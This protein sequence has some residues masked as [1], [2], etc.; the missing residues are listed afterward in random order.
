[1]P[2]IKL[3]QKIESILLMANVKMGGGGGQGEGSRKES[4]IC[5]SVDL[6]H[7]QVGE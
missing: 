7:S 4:D 1:M 2:D 6:P 5:L 3:P